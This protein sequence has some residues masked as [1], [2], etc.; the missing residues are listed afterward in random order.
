[1]IDKT[2]EAFQSRKLDEGYDQV[3]QRVWEPNVSNEPHAH[4]FDTDAVVAKGE[5]WLTINGQA[6]H[7]KSGDGFKVSRDVLHSEKYGPQGAVFWAARKN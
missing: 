6:N 1:M 2:F 5:F 7:Y 3:L 4:P